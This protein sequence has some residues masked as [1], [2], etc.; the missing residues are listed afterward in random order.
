MELRKPYPSSLLGRAQR[1]N[2]LVMHPLMHMLWIKVWERHLRSE[3]FQ[4]NTRPPAQRSSARKISPHNFWLQKPVGIESVEET[5]GAPSSFFYRAHSWTHLLRLPPSELQ[6]QGS[7][8]KST[9]G[10]QQETEVSG[11]KVSRGHCPFSIPSPQRASK[12]V[13]YLR[14]HQPG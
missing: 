9:S 6:H 2:R 5:S 11:I 13:P 10:I 8:L 1:W 14:L 3:E 7:S 4:P 12:L